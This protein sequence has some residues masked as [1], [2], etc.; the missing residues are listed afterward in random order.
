M[1]KTFVLFFI[2]GLLG[3]KLSAQSFEKNEIIGDWTVSKINIVGELTAEQLQ[4]M[5]LFEN[6]FLS[7]KF[8]FDANQSFVFDFVV[9]EMAISN[10]HWKYEKST[11]SFIIQKW[12]DKDSDQKVLMKFKVKKKDGKIIFTLLELPFT[13]EMKKA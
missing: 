8:K 1:K 13:L 6:A 5:Q 12:E 7:S 9:K 4:M 3:A 2:I 11:E 10:G